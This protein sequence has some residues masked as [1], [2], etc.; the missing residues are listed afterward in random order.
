MICRAF[1]SS[2]LAERVVRRQVL[3]LF[4]WQ[5]VWNN[6]GEGCFKEIMTVRAG[7]GEPVRAVFLSGNR[8]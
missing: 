7:V 2:V 4:C 8:V 6:A 5:G 3:A 1:R